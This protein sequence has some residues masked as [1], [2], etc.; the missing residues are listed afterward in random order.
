MTTDEIFKAWKK[1]LG[2]SNSDIAQMLGYKNLNAMVTGG[3]W[4]KG[5][6]QQTC[7]AMWSCANS[8]PKLIIT[9]CAQPSAT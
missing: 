9:P 3:R 5:M 4:R 1:H 6:I 8:S 2:L 7:V